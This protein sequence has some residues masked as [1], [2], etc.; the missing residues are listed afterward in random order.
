MAFAN[1]TMEVFFAEP[2]MERLRQM[3]MT[4]GII[5]TALETYAV[6]FSIGEGLAGVIP[7]D[8]DAALSLPYGVATMGNILLTASYGTGQ[9]RQT[10][11][12]SGITTDFAGRR[13]EG[14]FPVSSTGDG[15]PATFATLAGPVAVTVDHGRQVVYIAESDSGQI[16]QVNLSSGLISTLLASV[17][18][19]GETRSLYS[20]SL[21]PLRQLLYASSPSA[22]VVYGYRLESS[23]CVAP[24]SISNAASPACAE[25]TEVY[26]DHCT[27]QCANGYEPNVPYLHCS[28]GVLTPSSFTCFEAPC[29]A[30]WGI[31]H[32]SLPSCS[33][34][35]V[36]ASGSRCTAQCNT[37]E[38]DGNLTCD[39]GTLQPTTF[40]CVQPTTLTV[41]VTGGQSVSGGGTV[42]AAPAP[43]MVN[44]GS[45]STVSNTELQEGIF[46]DIVFDPSIAPR[47]SVAL[48]GSFTFE[49]LTAGLTLS[50]VSLL[51]ASEALQQPLREALV[52]MLKL[53]PGDLHLLAL[54]PQLPTQ[55]RLAE[56]AT[57]THGFSVA[58]TVPT[59]PVWAELRFNALRLGTPEAKQ[60]WSKSLEQVHFI[61]AMQEISMNRNRPC[62]LPPS[63]P[64]AP[65]VPCQEGQV[66]TSSLDLCS[67]KCLTPLL[68]STDSL[69]CFAGFWSPSTFSC[70]EAHEEEL[71]CPV[72]TG[73]PDAADL[74]C[75]GIQAS[76]ASGSFC[77]PQCRVGLESSEPVLACIRGDLQPSSFS[78]INP[79]CVAPNVSQAQQPSCLEGFVVPATRQCTA[80]CLPGFRATANLSCLLGQLVPSRF[81]CTDSAVAESDSAATDFWGIGGGNGVLSTTGTSSATESPA[82]LNATETEKDSANDFWGF[83][84]G[85]T[86]VLVAA[87]AGGIVVLCL[88]CCLWIVL[89]RWCQ[90]S[91]A[92]KE[93]ATSW[94]ST[95]EEV[96]RQNSVFDSPPSKSPRKRKS[97]GVSL[98]EATKDVAN[99]CLEG[100]SDSNDVKEILRMM[101]GEQEGPANPEAKVEDGQDMAE[102]LRDVEALDVNEVEPEEG[103]EPELLRLAI[104]AAEEVERTPQDAASAAR[105]KDAVFE[106]MDR[107]IGEAVAVAAEAAPL[108]SKSRSWIAQKPEKGQI[109]DK[110]TR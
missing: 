87:F 89:R 13:N 9:V 1:G 59:P 79:D 37:G 67:T 71:S 44:S 103:D 66:T 43:S 11:L 27:T 8:Y 69:R 81:L 62:R 85:Q 95:A 15:G 99:N 45:V 24:V 109:A 53:L 30:P 25:G 20:L 76:I 48:N 61:E 28:S 29:L 41:T 22:M 54:L 47:S 16:R 77:T 75:Q 21:D 91:A 88:L 97:S 93:A 33:E 106:A 110:S 35:M 105:K 100:S 84:S 101:A 3:D 83:V 73:I 94:E 60:A 55:R 52:E 56:S 72:P 86:F 74:P 18:P 26:V 34:G 57:P 108:Q 6:N 12:T 23:A 82:T 49:A 4:S 38:P 64:D 68:P 50:E 63:P 90:R 107:D 78:C 98:D 7:M 42:T 31:A 70:L 17:P 14:Y 102:T 5:D 39:R 104:E 19:A 58:F 10:N 92:A 96:S 36:I 51:C 46:G 40:T 2:A 80:A 65:P 32:S